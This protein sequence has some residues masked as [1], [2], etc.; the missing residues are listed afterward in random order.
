[1]LKKT[2]LVGLVVAAAFITGCT[3]VPMA[4][5]TRDAKAKTFSVSADKANVYV[6]RN[7]AMGGA[8]KMD[9]ALNGKPLGQSAAKTYF[10]IEVPPGKHTL[11]SKAENDSTLDLVAEAGKNYFVWQEVKM[12]VLYARNQLQLVDE[13][14]GKAGVAE[15][16]LIDAKY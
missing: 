1:M 7:E 16:K 12:G 9:V 15:C 14:T 8:V 6:Y 3:S 11:V 13:S 4:D 10:A 5:V 2:S